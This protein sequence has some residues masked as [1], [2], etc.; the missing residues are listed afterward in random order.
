MNPEYIVGGIVV[1][2]VLFLLYK[3]FFPAAVAAVAKTLP[4][5]VALPLVSANATHIVLA[6]QPAPAVA[7]VVVAAPVANT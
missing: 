3:H 2:V 5:A 7:A 4:V 1:V 6:T